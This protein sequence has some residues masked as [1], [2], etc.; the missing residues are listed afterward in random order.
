MTESDTY[1]PNQK[2]PRFKTPG[3][4][5]CN[6]KQI[7]NT[8]GITMLHLIVQ[9]LLRNITEIRLLL[10]ENNVHVISFI[11]TCLDGSVFDSKIYINILM[12]IV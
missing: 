8:N 6:L 4:A 9:S 5:S 1:L 11:K 3:T 7:G 10:C 2:M 12:A